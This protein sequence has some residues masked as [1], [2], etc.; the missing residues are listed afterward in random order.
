M[1]NRMPSIRELARQIRNGRTTT[2]QIVDQCLQAIAEREKDINA[3]ITVLT[4]EAQAHARR[5]E[6]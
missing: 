6:P 4:D 2:L 5:P 1:P 3:F